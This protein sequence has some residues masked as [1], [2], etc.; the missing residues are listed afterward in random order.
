MNTTSI[1]YAGIPYLRLTIPEYILASRSPTPE[2]AGKLLLS[3]AANSTSVASTSSSLQ[4]FIMRQSFNLD[5]A[6]IHAITGLPGNNWYDTEI[7]LNPDIRV[8]AM[9]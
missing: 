9:A 7:S 6:S 5:Q 4:P 2:L 8:R 1:F 3:M